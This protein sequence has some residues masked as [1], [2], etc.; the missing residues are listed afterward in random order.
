M[1]MQNLPTPSHQNHAPARSVPALRM[2]KEPLNFW[3][4]KR[5]ARREVARLRS[6]QGEVED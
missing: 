1:A 4:T 6:R 2:P 3:D 5:L